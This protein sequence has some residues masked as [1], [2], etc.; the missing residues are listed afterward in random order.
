MSELRHFEL[1]LA[2]VRPS[3]NK[4]MLKSF[5]EFNQQYGSYQFSLDELEE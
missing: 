5:Q 3:V 1:A 2:L 4:K